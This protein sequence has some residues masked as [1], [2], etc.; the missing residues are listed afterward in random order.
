MKQETGLRVQG[1][2]SCGR[3]P[4]R[5]EKSI[6][7]IISILSTTSAFR[8]RRRGFT[9]VEMLVVVLIMALLMGLLIRTL[10][11]AGGQADRAATQAKIEKVKAAL[12]EFFAEYGQYPPVPFYE[13]IQPVRLEYPMEYTGKWKKWSGTDF[14]DAYN[15]KTDDPAK[16]LFTLGLVAF[17]KPRY[18]TVKAGSP[19]FN[20]NVSQLYKNK[21]WNSYTPSQIDQERDLNAVKRWEPFLDGVIGGPRGDGF[22]RGGTDQNPHH[23][24]GGQTIYDSWDHELHYESLPPHQSYKIWSDGP[25]KTDE[26]GGGDDIGVFMK[27]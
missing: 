18:E 10:G 14:L 7:S 3:S 23:V 6:L 16:R 2:G 24:N 4:R 15:E 5:P 27:K 9:L 11:G 13:G 12:E 17:L 22:H 8:S 20:D 21:Q 25:N 1:S 26:K 19:Y